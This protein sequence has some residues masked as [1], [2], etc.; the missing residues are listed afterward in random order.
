MAE[1]TYGELV[2]FP[3]GSTFTNRRALAASGVHRP[4]Q[5]G[6]C[7]GQDGAES[8]VVSGG[9]VDDEDFG[10]EI[11]Y[12]G[13][14]GRDPNTGE[15]T[16]DQELTRGNVGLARSKME[17]Y[18]VRVVRG[19]GGEEPFSPESGLRYDGLFRV[20]DFWHETG[21]NGFRVWR[22]RLVAA[23]NE[24]VD[25]TDYQE[26]GNPGPVTRT[27]VTIQ[28]LV[29]STA[30][31]QLVKELHQYSCQVCGIRI[32]TPAGPYAEAAHIRALGKPHD[33]PDVQSNVLCLCPNHHVMFD[34]GAIYIEQD[35]TVRDS[36]NRRPISQLRRVPQHVID[37]KQLT[38]H[39]DH[40]AP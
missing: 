35:W 27:A 10:D 6:I 17:G 33:G 18:L 5:G 36:V 12:T 16:E 22:F 1:R 20:A 14:G 19:A 15:Q 25:P 21:R 40:Y 7:G 24:A 3:H 4:L 13:Q 28:R 8:I 37:S 32:N 30:V 2:G 11:V 9:Y 29:R 26:H 31:A 38:Y 34:A 23:H 39:Q